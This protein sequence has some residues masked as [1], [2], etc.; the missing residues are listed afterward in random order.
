MAVVERVTR[1]VEGAGATLTYDVHGDPAEAGA[2]NPALLLVG[3]PMEAS[4]FTTLASHF[5]DRVVVTYDPRGTGR[6]PRTDGAEE[7]TPQ[8]HADDLRRVIEDLGAGPVELFGSSGGAVNGLA[9]VAA[10]P[11][12]V[13][14]FVAHEPPVPAVLPDGPHALAAC[15][16]VHRTY[17]RSGMGPAM[18]KFIAVTG[19]TGPFPENWADEPAP[20]PAAFGLPTEDDGRRDDPLLGQNMRAC[21]GYRPDFEALAAAARST[22]IVLAV[23]KESEGQLCARAAAATAARLG[24]EPVVFPSHH[25]GFLGGEFGQQGEPEAFAA[26]LREV[27]AA[28]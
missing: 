10:H 16:D 9:L 21:T 7:T 28:G 26:T 13:R 6:S 27:L 3:S 1:T 15:E 23:G 11:D 19:R 5:T 8:E 20:D 22:R 12:L 18:A 4:G 2:D 24:L 14:T 17:L 25:A